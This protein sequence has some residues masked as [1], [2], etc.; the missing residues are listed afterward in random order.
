[1]NDDDYIPFENFRKLR[2]P[3][4]ITEMEREALDATL[5]NAKACKFKRRRRAKPGGISV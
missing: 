5:H 4:S 3:H 2:D 1:L